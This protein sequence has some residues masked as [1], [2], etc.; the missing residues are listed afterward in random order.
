MKMNA[1][2]EVSAVVTHP[3]HMGKGYAK[4]LVT[5]TANKIFDQN[6]TPYLHVTETNSAAINLYKK[7]GFVTRRKISFLNLVTNKK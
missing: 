3:D 2:I 1:N 7:L 4:Q 6:K 5:Y